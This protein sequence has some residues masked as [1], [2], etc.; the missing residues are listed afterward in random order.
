MEALRLAIIADCKDSL[1]NPKNAFSAASQKDECACYNNLNVLV[2]VLQEEKYK[3][4]KWVESWF[5]SMEQHIIHK[6]C[7]HAWE[8]GRSSAAAWDIAEKKRV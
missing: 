5:S 3:E 6:R 1:A 8:K 7:K 2:R 4:D